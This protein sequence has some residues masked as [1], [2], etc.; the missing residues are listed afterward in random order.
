MEFIVIYIIKLYIYSIEVSATCK[1][2]VYHDCIIVTYIK[3]S[4]YVYQ[5]CIYINKNSLPL[6]IPFISTT[7][8]Y[9]GTCKILCLSSLFHFYI[10]KNNSYI[11]KFNKTKCQWIF[12]QMQTTFHVFKEYMYIP[13]THKQIFS[14]NR[15]S[16]SV[17]IKTQLSL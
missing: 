8:I 9:F 2:H 12:R 14:A 6:H 7:Q 11:L 3:I 4:G 10:Y 17:T 1:L 16:T 13:H 5:N 15:G